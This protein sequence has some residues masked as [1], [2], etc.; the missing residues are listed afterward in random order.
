MENRISIHSLRVEGDNDPVPFTSMHRS[1]SIHSLRVEGD[2]SRRYSY[3]TI[4]T[5]QSTPSGW[6]ETGSIIQEPT[7]RIISIHSLRVEGDDIAF[8]IKN[9]LRY[10]NPLPPGG[11]RH[12]CINTLIQYFNPLPPGGGR[13]LVVVIIRR[14]HYF[15]PL[16]P[17]GGRLQKATS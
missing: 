14:E 8:K 12:Y 15:N 11:G 6:R 13:L 2:Q 5:F 16:P 9:R 10:F 7:L 4:L 17:G 1:I 3:R